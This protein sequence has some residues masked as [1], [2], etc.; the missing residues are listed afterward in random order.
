[1]AGVIRGADF[2]KTR[3]LGRGDTG[4]LCRLFA[5]A[6]TVSVAAANAAAQDTAAPRSTSPFEMARVVN[7]SHRLWEKQHVRLDVD[8]AR[9]WERLGVEEGD[10]AGCSGDCEAQTFRHELDG[11]PGSE[12]VLKLTQ[13]FDYC[14]FLVFKRERARRTRGPAWRLLGV[15]DH[16]FNRYEMARHRVVPALGRNWLVVR[17]QEGSGTGYSLYTETW[18]EVSAKGVRPVLYYPAQGHVAPWPSGVGRAFKARVAEARG[19]AKGVTLDYAVTYEKLDYMKD[20]FSK[21]YR[22]RHRVRYV[23]DEGRRAFAFDAARSDIS[24][25]EVAAIAE[26][27]TEPG[28]GEK[29]G[30]SEFFSDGDAWKRGGYD[31]FLKYNLTRLLRV[32]RR[33]GERDKEWLRQL[34]KDCAD[35]REKRAL[36][37]AL[38]GRK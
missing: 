1:M 28:E 15:V 21:L 31:L 35:T 13:S 5:A 2:L 7:E 9:T 17:G 27:E 16:D 36:E 12:V 29:I 11:E 6:L 10:F 32:A 3:R 38:R 33:G 22:N 23:W 4:V 26:L 19:R 8:L 18:Y 25:E 37:A 24:E 34:L 20:R 30:G 14:R